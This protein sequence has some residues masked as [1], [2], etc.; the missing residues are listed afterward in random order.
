MGAVASLAAG[1]SSG[2]EAGGAGSL[3]ANTVVAVSDVQRRFGA[4]ARILSIEIDEAGAS[5]A[6]QDA[7]VGA[8]VDRHRWRVYVEGPRG[9]GYVEFGLD[10]KR[11][12]VTRW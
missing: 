9:G 4:D 5:I 11:K 2:G 8:H 3:A 10:G 1:A 7:A 6:V 12:R